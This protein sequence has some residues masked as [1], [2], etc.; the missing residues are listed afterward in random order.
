MV[1][2][3][4]FSIKMQIIT[5]ADRQTCK[6][7]TLAAE[8]RGMSQLSVYLVKTIVLSLVD[9]SMLLIITRMLCITDLVP[10]L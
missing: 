3:V 4:Y 8:K 7:V 10:F 5:P 1:I 2:V 9:G 6:R